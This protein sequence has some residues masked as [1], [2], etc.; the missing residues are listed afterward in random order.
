MMYT[1]IGLKV[2]LIGVT[3]GSCAGSGE[4]HKSTSV[5]QDSVEGIPHDV[6]DLGGLVLEGLGNLV[7]EDPAKLI[8]MQL[9]ELSIR[10]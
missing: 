6:V 5:K 3:L 10:W 8:L 9:G 1:L 2:S 4:L 7:P